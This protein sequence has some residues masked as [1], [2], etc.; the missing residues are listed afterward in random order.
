MDNLIYLFVA[1]SIIWLVVLLY[2]YSNGA[3]Q[4]SLERE[5]QMLKDVVAEKSRL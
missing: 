1:Y 3:R 4:R 5:I 2:S